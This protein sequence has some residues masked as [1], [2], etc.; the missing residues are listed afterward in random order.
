M[1]CKASVWGIQLANVESFIK[2]NNEGFAI[3]A[4]GLFDIE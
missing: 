4:M 1:T 2:N 3:I